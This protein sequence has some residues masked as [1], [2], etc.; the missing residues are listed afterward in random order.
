MMKT[1][2]IFFLCFVVVSLGCSP[3]SVRH[4]Y[5]TT[6]D[7]SRLKNYSWLPV[8]V[9]A[10]INELDVKRIQ[11]AVN[12]Q[13]QAKGYAMAPN[14]DFLIAMHM[15]S[16]EKIQVTDW[17]Y[18]YGPRGRYWGPGRVDVYQYEE[19]TLILDFVDTRTKELIWRGVATGEIDRYASPEKREKKINR[20]VEK[21][22]KKFPPH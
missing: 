15:G 16:Q 4:D 17:G 11:S 7:F 12:S 3:V 18:N 10:N 8:P 2:S 22:L 20:V 21:I 13:L 1:M 6:A 19:G 14:P 5:D 9:Q